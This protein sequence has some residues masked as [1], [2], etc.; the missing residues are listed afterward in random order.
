MPTNNVAN[1]TG[2]LHP[3]ASAGAL[4]NMAATNQP[5]L[6]PNHQFAYYPFFPPPYPSYHPQWAT[7]AGASTYLPHPQMPPPQQQQPLPQTTSQLPTGN[8]GD[9]IRHPDAG[10]WDTAPLRYIDNWTID[11]LFPFSGSDIN[12]ENPLMPPNALFSNATTDHLQNA[13]L[14]AAQYIFA[15]H[16]PHPNY[17][18]QTASTTNSPYSTIPAYHTG[19]GPATILPAMQA[20]SLTQPSNSNMNDIQLQTQTQNQS[21]TVTSQAHVPTMTSPKHETAPMKNTMT[22]GT[23]VNN[24]AKTASSTRT[25]VGAPN[26]TET[27]PTRPN[28]GYQTQMA[29]L[30]SLSPSMINSQPSQA[31]LLSPITVST[32][33]TNIAG[34]NATATN[35][36]N[37]PTISKAQTASLTDIWGYTNTGSPINLTQAAAQTAAVTA[38]A[39]MGLLNNESANNVGITNEFLKGLATPTKPNQ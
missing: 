8:L 10:Q 13:Q 18:P 4:P 3:Y 33:N 23:A 27:D 29:D 25:S 36:S 16:H 34:T 38:V 5:F 32:N 20:L 12:S 30:L 11:G 24:L 17:L 9:P 22:A 26:G 7:L 6:L 31:S 19:P 2:L 14:A 39:A 21:H 1:A 35:S 37:N 28:T 15:S